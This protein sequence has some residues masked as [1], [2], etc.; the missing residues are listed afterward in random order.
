[1]TNKI[2][3]LNIDFSFKKNEE[4]LV[5]DIRTAEVMLCESIVGDML[6]KKLEENGISCDVKITGK[7][8]K[9]VFSVT[10]VAVSVEL[11]D[12][13]KLKVKQLIAEWFPEAETYF[14]EG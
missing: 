11:T 9:E 12:E 5:S 10:A 3:Q 7:K 4:K 14:G 13:E 8:H 1:M 6:K 2:D